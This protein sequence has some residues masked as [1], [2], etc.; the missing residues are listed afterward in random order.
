MPALVAMAGVVIVAGYVY[1]QDLSTPRSAP[2]RFDTL[3]HPSAPD[4][5]QAADGGGASLNDMIG[6]D[7]A[8]LMLRHPGDRALGPGDGVIPPH[9]DGVEA[10]GVRRVT[11]ML[12]EEVLAYRVPGGDLEAVR[13]HHRRA[14]EDAGFRSLARGRSEAAS[15]VFVRVGPP[16]HK[17]DQSAVEQTLITRVSRRGDDVQALIWLRYPLN[18]AAP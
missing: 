10:M 18:R 4:M 7:P 15:D 17:P 13:A 9:P 12:V 3:V 14:A 2:P 6:I 16:P 8:G 5:P 1:L 11:A